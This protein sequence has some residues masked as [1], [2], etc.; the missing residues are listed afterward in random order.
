MK[1]LLLSRNPNPF[2]VNAANRFY[3]NQ[4]SAPV[5]PPF[6]LMQRNYRQGLTVQILR[7]VLTHPGVHHSQVVQVA[8]LLDPKLSS[9]HR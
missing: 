4:A 6:G 8:S 7:L 3:T 5:L 9:I 2:P 1:A